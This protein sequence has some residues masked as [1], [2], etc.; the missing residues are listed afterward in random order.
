MGYA[1]VVRRTENWLM[2]WAEKVVASSKK[3]SCTPGANSGAS[4]LYIFKNNLK[5]GTQ[6]TLLGIADDTKP[7]VG[8]GVRDEPDGCAATQ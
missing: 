3:S 1:S 6:S 8:G 7:G 4:T 5:N 2:G